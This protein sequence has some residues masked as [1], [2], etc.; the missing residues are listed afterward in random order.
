M[1]GSFAWLRPIER[2]IFRRDTKDLADADSQTLKKIFYFRT[3]V[4]IPVMLFV[5]ILASQPLKHIGFNRYAPFNSVFP[6]TYDQKH[7]ASAKPAGLAPAVIPDG[8]PRKVKGPRCE[9]GKGTAVPVHPAGGA[10]HVQK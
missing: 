5:T 7:P 1:Q 4:F 10:S 3:V 2:L 6:T 8:D 9:I